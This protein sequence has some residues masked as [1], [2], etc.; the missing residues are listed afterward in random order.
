MSARVLYFDCFSGVAGDMTLGALIDLGVDATAL[1]AALQT[2]PLPEWRLEVGATHKMGIRGVDVHVV[3]GDRVEG[4]D[5][6]VAHAGT[7]AH[8]P[9]PDDHHDHHHYADIVSI[10]RG[11]TLPEVVVERALA[12]FEALAVAEAKVHGVPKESVHFHEV[13]AVDSIVDIVGSAWG[14]WRL[15]VDRVE[16]A[17]PPVARGFVRC[18]HGRMPSPAPATL[19][20]LTGLPVEGTDIRRELVTPTGA[21]FLRT[22]AERVGAFPAMVI[23]RVGFGA[24]DLDLD[25]RPNLLRLVLGRTDPA[26]P[27]CFVV[28][29]NVD[30]L[31]PEIAGYLLERLFEVGARDAWFVPLHMKK[32]RPGFLVGAL[33]DRATRG[34]VEETLLSE[35]SAIGLRSYPVARRVLDRSSE[36][37]E[38]PFGPVPVKVAREGDRILNA[39]PEYEACRAIA[40]EAG[41]PLKTVYQHAV[42][43][44]VLRA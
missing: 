24:G 28:E 10:I 26:A 32:D 12:A 33:A 25:D 31:S 5:G 44:F 37:V 2:L 23:E 18:A 41:V 7:G 34:A 43:A 36:T 17:P 38:T 9:D 15:G 14:I 16:S 42:A 39:A 3:V 6:V 11:G 13:G 8:A 21:A 35:S 1:E 19:E 40:R 4:P 30:D 22:W 20:I 27:D 29:T